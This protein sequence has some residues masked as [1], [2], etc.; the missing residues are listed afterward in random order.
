MN[1]I[2][3]LIPV[4]N[5]LDYTIECLNILRQKKESAF[6]TLNKIDIIVID[7]ASTDG[8]NEYLKTYYPEIIL[9]QGTGN[10]WWSGSM[11]LGVKHALYALGCDFVLTWENDI[12]PQSDYFDNLQVILND[13]TKDTLVCSKIMVKDCPGKIFSVGGIFNSSTGKKYLIGAG[14]LDGKDYEK[15]FEVDWFCGQGILIHKIVFEKIGFFDE[16]RFPQYHG[17]SDFALRAKKQGFR[18]IVF[19]S[20]VIW[21]DT[22]TTGISHIKNKT[23]KQMLLSIFSIRSN[24]NILKDVQFYNRHSTKTI[25]YWQLVIK[26][27][28]YIGGFFKW[29]FLG[30]FN[31][32]KTTT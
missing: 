16:K 2:A 17:D 32:F 30:L 8:T 15:S 7:D 9:L 20:L 3:I 10:L 23:F 29:K 22:S 24:Y 25:A 18:N 14:E 19:P 28:K 27:S 13:W 26:Y 6:F 31:I 21:N 4:F 1:K 11:N 12:T 5:R